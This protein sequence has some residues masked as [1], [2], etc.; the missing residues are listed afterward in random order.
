[1]GS[2]EHVHAGAAPAFRQGTCTAIDYRAA[3]PST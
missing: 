3:S 2:Q 1:M